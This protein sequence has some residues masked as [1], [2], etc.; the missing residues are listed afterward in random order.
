MTSGIEE[1]I[2]NEL[3]I[4]RSAE[5]IKARVN[6]Y[7][8][9]VGK[10]WFATAIIGQVIFLA[11]VIALYAGALVNNNL[12]KWNLIIPRAY[13][14]DDPLGNIA[15]GIH[16]LLAVIIM[17]GGP[18]QMLPQIRKK[19][20][21]FHRW[22]GRTY[23][24]TVIPVALAGLFMFFNR[25]EDT[26]EFSLVSIAIPLNGILLLTIAAIALKHA[27]NKSFVQ[28]RKWAMRL[29]IQANAIWFFRV[30]LMFW[31]AINDGKIVGFDEHTFQGPVITFL[32]FAQYA[33]PLLILELYF[34]AQSQRSGIIKFATA[35]ILL[36][37]TG[38]M[39]IG[40]FAASFFMWFPAMTH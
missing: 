17:L 14:P 7:L 34:Y 22:V 24:A 3:V 40:I 25:G 35:S 39:A 13:V 10:L 20:P 16:V 11:Y 38:V 36:L 4:N 9:G 8:A 30:G 6:G 26:N 5:W 18:L 33:L 15:V 37:L 12:E 32:S 19:Y 28:H 29:F 21:K 23:I 1:N 2:Q 31:I 27:L